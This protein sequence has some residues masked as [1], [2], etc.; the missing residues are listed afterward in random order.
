MSF[1][2]GILKCLGMIQF[3]CKATCL[4]QWDLAVTYTKSPR[5]WR[6]L[7]I[8]DAAWLPQLRFDC[9]TRNLD[10]CLVFFWVCRVTTELWCSREDVCSHY[11]S[12]DWGRARFL[13]YING[14]SKLRASFFSWFH[15][16]ILYYKLERRALASIFSFLLDLFW[17]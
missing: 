9:E 5:Y 10:W 7:P 6:F 2:W 15:I 16:H 3:L 8:D 4:P 11:L 13:L 1:L 17:L 12:Q 14:W